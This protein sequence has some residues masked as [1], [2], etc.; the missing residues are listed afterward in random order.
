MRA[1][2]VGT[3]RLAGCDAWV[4]APWH[5]ALSQTR[6]RTQVP[7]IG[8]WILHHWTTRAVPTRT[9]VDEGP[10]P[11]LAPLLFF[12]G[13]QEEK[14][15]LTPHPLHSPVPLLQVVKLKQ[16]EHTLNEKRIL[17]AVNF[18][19]LVKLEFSFKVGFQWR[20][21]GAAARQ[22]SLWVPRAGAGPITTSGCPLLGRG[23]ADQPGALI[24]PSSTGPASL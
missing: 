1:S 14:D 8:R 7:C 20:Q 12:L 10:G 9:I 13:G 23:R 4:A 3:R 6:D 22:C 2:V 17:Q 16:I 24:A 19:F 18:P 11:A 21:T 5:V 15:S